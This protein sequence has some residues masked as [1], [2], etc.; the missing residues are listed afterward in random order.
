ME[1][2]KSRNDVESGQQRNK[3]NENPTLNKSI[4][5]SLALH[6]YGEALC[7][8]RLVMGPTLILSLIF[9]IEVETRRSVEAK[10]IVRGENDGFSQAE[11]IFDRRETSDLCGMQFSNAK[12]QQLM[13]GCLFMIEKV[14]ID[15]LVSV[16]VR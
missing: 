3:S 13:I 8:K 12:D 7:W 15:V 4:N 5:E 11:K 9:F 14:S 6:E 16:I 10:F 2:V 1:R